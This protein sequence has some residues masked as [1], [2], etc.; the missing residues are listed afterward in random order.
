MIALPP[1]ARLGI[2][3]TRVPMGSGG[4]RSPADIEADIPR[5]AQLPAD[6]NIDLIDLQGAG[7]VMERGSDSEAA[8]VKAIEAAT[9]RGTRGAPAASEV[10]I[11]SDFYAL[12]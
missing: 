6:V 9:D 7:I 8:V 11:G 3:I 2:H 1:T 4:E 10:P 12:S 5:C